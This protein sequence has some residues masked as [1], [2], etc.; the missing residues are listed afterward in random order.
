[1]SGILHGRGFARSVAMQPALQKLEAAIAGPGGVLVC[2]EP[3]TGREVMARAIHRGTTSGVNGTL[4]DLLRDSTRPFESGIPFVIV[5]CITGSDIEE[6]V[7]GTARNIHEGLDYIS[8]GSRLHR[9]FG[10][11]LFLRSVHEMPGRVQA[12]LARVL[13]D[14]EVWVHSA[15]DPP[16][17]EPVK[18]RPIASIDAVADSLVDEHVTPEL[19]RRLAA[20]RIKLPP[21]RERRED[22]PG[23]VRLL[24]TDICRSLNVQVKCASRQAVA[25]LSALP[26]RGNFVELCGLLR[27]LVVKVPGRLIRLSDVL[28]NIRLDGS[29]VTFHGRGTLKEARERFEREYVAAILELHRGRMAEA[30]R[31]LGIQRTNLYRKIRQ[32]A[33]QRK[34]G[35]RV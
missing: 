29:A 5:D 8:S 3:G 11:T 33:V 21:L 1:M 6:L 19:Q 9:A 15:S 24:L 25:L 35:P 27:A 12:R 28:A 26:W 16:S 30:A 4:E 17:V 2:G 10:G 14:G 31:A 20:H 22:I 18:V 34:N 32:L 23:L 13:R 7:F